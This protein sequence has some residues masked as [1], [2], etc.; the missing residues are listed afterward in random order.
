MIDRLRG[1][2]IRL[3]FFEIPAKPLLSYRNGWS[4]MGIDGVIKT[5]HPKVKAS[6]P[7]RSAVPVPAVA[8]SFA[9]TP[10]YTPSPARHPTLNAPHYNNI[11]LRVDLLMF[12]RDGRC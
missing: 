3:L 6:S 12:L 7:P 5:S 2:S 10:T 9:P 4:H 11:R 1:I 8:P